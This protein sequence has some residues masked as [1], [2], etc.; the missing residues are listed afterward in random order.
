MPHLQFDITIDPAPRETTRFTAWAREQYA[1]VMDTGTGHIAVTVHPCAPTQLSLGR[2]TP[3][4]AD[5]AVMNADVRRGRTLDQRREFATTVM[6][7]LHDRWG[8]PT[9]H[10]YVVYTEHPGADFM[11]REGP[12]DSWEPGDTPMDEGSEVQR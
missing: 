7:E 6:E 1:D 3:A 12:L 4:G 8:I 2:A 9:D 5:V 10:M 11:L